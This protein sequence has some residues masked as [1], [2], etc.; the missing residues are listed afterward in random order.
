MSKRVPAPLE[1]VRFVDHT[2]YPSGEKRINHRR[3]VGQVKYV[4]D[5]TASE[6]DFM[7]LCERL[8]T[9]EDVM[10]T[11]MDAMEIDPMTRIEVDLKLSLFRNGF[12]AAVGDM[13]DASYKVGD[14]EMHRRMMN[15]ADYAAGY[16]AGSTCAEKALELYRA[17]LEGR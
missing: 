3:G 4:H 12:G 10:A 9:K 5:V 7:R 1:N 14:A 2:D 11:E 6:L 17:A 16:S 15:D 13:T 8:G